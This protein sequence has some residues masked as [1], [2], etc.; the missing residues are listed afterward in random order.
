MKVSGYFLKQ[1]LF[2]SILVVIGLIILYKPVK[3]EQDRTETTITLD[4]LLRIPR[5]LSNYSVLTANMEVRLDDIP[6]WISCPPAVINDKL[7]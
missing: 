2:L 5:R 6:N 1:S 4:R 3:Y 7:V